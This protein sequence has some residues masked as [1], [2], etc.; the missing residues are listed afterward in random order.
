MKAN[1]DKCHVLLSTNKNILVNT[2]TAQM[3][4]STSAK[5]LEVKI[6]CKLKFKDHIGDICK[7][8][9]A[10]LNALTSVS[11][12]MNPDEK[13]VVMNGSVSSQFAHCFWELVSAHTVQKMK[14]YIKDFF[15]KCDQ[16]HRQHFLCSVN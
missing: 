7:R 6:D 12:Y 2:G 8:A 16:I 4:I 9:S 15:S 10:K 11:S 1:G 14:F 13:R 5:L 3:Q